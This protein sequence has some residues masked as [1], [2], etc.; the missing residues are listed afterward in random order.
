MIVKYFLWS[1]FMKNTKPGLAIFAIIISLFCLTACK[2]DDYEAAYSLYLGSEYEAAASAFKELGDYQNSAHW[3]TQA[4]NALDYE[5]AVS[6]YVDGDY[7]AAV[8]AFLE[9]GGYGYRDSNDRAI[10]AQA[11]LE[12]EQQLF[13]EVNEKLAEIEEYASSHEITDNYTTLSFTS[14]PDWYESYD[15]YSELIKKDSPETTALA[16]RFKNAMID[17]EELRFYITIKLNEGLNSNDFD[18]LE[19][20]VSHI[21]SLGFDDKTEEFNEKLQYFYFYNMTKTYTSYFENEKAQISIFPDSEVKTITEQ[22]LSIWE[23]KNDDKLTREDIELAIS[24]SDELE[25]LADSLQDMKQP[26]YYLKNCLMALGRDFKNYDY[27]YYK[28]CHESVEDNITPELE[29]YYAKTSSGKAPIEITGNYLY[30]KP[31]SYHG[32]SATDLTSELFKTGSQYNMYYA[33]KPEEARY[34]VTFSGTASPDGVYQF[35]GSIRKTQAYKVNITIC[36]K[37]CK[38]GKIL[39]TQNISADAP[40]SIKVG[41]I[42]SEYYAEAIW[43]DDDINKLISELKSVLEIE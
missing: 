7:A 32:F 34:L 11:A 33:S 3:A 12:K 37:D 10:L 30:V 25:D 2:S 16:E 29:T 31:Y 4:Q 1:L 20:I 9:L 5:A 18:S 42:P 19:W 8:S 22:A 36:L 41:D 28:Q 43:E 14:F 17:I 23:T 39:H 21:E 15:L 6:L 38:T 24:L 40:D 13:K 27:Y 26:D 35:T